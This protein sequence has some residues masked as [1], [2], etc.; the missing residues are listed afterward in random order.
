M[1]NALY[2]SGREA[3]LGTANWLTDDFRVVLLTS[4]YVA[5]LS[6]HDNLD[7]ISAGARVATSGALSSKTATAGVADAADVLFPALTGSTVTQ[8]IIY[9]HT[10][11]ESTST[12]IAYFNIAGGLAFTP[13][14]SDKTIAWSNGPN[15]IFKL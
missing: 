5:N 4:A 2:D 13:D 1:S 9:K 10:G 8:F 14:G 11:T 3:F 7:D 12:L 6:T 15:K